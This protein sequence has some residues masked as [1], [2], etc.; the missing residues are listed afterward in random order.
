M[1]SR[2][3]R[4]ADVLELDINDP[5]HLEA[6]AADLDSRWGALDGVL[7]AIAFVP[8]DA[9]GGNFMTAPPQSAMTALQ[10]SSVSYKTLAAGLAGL[11]EKG[12]GSIIGLDFDAH[13]AWPSYDWAGVTKAA[14][15]SI[16]RYV[17]RDLGPRGIRSNLVSAGPLNTMAAKSIDGFSELSKI[18]EQ[19]AP[20]GWNLDDALPVADA[21]VFLFSS[22]AR[23][24]TGEIIHVDGGVHALGA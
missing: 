21:C 22:L 6:V 8:A 18:W 7:H 14:L 16:N 5:A 3:P 4:P 12:E 2:L 20:L 10:I 23:G 13:V 24:I 17:A 15:E 1:A 19:R 11:L 9:L